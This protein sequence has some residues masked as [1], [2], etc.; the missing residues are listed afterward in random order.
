MIYPSYWTADTTLVVVF[1]HFFALLTFYHVGIQMHFI[2]QFVN[3]F[4]GLFSSR[5]VG[6][7]AQ[8]VPPELISTK[9]NKLSDFLT[10][11]GKLQSLDSSLSLFLSNVTPV[12]L[13]AI[14]TTVYLQGAQ[15]FVSLLSFPIAVIIANQIFVPVFYALR[16]KTANQVLF[17]RKF[18]RS[19]VLIKFPIRFVRVQSTSASDSIS[20]SSCSAWFW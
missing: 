12:I 18:D 2:Q 15:Y 16:I 8:K 14:P 19:F 6:L 20:P 5:K 4:K 3:R 9:Y 11:R 7:A 1:F 10:G 17:S 13:L